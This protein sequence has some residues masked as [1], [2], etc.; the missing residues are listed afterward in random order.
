MIYY[1]RRMNSTNLA[2]L[3]ILCGTR[4]TRVEFSCINDSTSSFH[5]IHVIDE[6][7]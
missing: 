3:D 5:V 1:L 4:V 2:F 6:K 7:Q